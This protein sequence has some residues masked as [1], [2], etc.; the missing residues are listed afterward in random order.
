MIKEKTIEIRITSNI[1]KHYI[2][3]YKDIKNGD[4]ITI[5]INDLYKGSTTK[6]T[7]ICDIC[8]KEKPIEYR[9]YIKSFNNGG[10]Y[11]CSS[12]CA[13]EKKKQTS[14]ENYGVEHHMKLDE[15]K[16]KLSTQWKD[17]SIDVDARTLKTKKTLL[18][19]YGDENYTVNKKYISRENDFL[20]IYCED[21]GENYFIHKTTHFERVKSGVKPCIYCNPLYS[22]KSK[23]E[24]DLSIF[25]KDIYDG[26]IILND[27]KI[28]NGLE[29]DIY[30][31]E[32]NLAFEF[33]GIYWHSSA[34]IDKKGYSL[35]KIQN[36]HKYKTDLCEEK[37]IELFH[38]FED[39]W[40]T[41]QEIVK[42]MIVNKMG[43][44]K[45]KIYGRK[46][47]IKEITDTKLVRD[48]LNN[49]HLQ[50]FASSSI[51]IGLFV[52]EE[53]VSLMTF[54]NNHQLLRFCNKLNTNI[55]GG[56]S[57][58]LKYY[59]KT[60]KPSEIKTYADRTY[61]NGEL[62]L[63]LGFKKYNTSK[64]SYFYIENKVRKHR[65]NFM[66]YKLVE[67]GFDASK[68]EF[69]IMDSRKIYRIYNSGTILFKKCYSSQS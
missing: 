63:T 51:K 60:Y 21:C 59:G 53:L 36:L 40:N 22:E 65:S 50:G 46:T 33:N 37:N 56:A 7:A 57:K 17:G 11:T 14:L 30:L 23:K 32:L 55:I 34:M 16:E 20:E 45:N 58:L 19:K 35:T 47:T 44:T 69:E 43:L 26:E 12:K 5:D 25:I 18:D 42:S 9:Y 10:Y 15:E 68:T 38:I 3:N 29:L 67:K 2:N 52:D 28:L 48:F 4:V 41:K 31:P 1:K 39:Q 62:Y 6:I 49:N 8:G 27:R 54:D 61:S 64:P 13:T 24:E 66:K